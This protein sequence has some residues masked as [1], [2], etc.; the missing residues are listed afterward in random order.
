[1][2]KTQRTEAQIISEAMGLLGSRKT[3]AKRE[4]ARRNG[5]ATRWKPKPLAEFE[6]RCSAGTDGADSAHKTYCPRGRA[7]RRRVQEG[8]V[9]VETVATGEMQ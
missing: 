3:E 1:M 6:C 8:T 7:Y 4:A 9:Q 2:A 5:A